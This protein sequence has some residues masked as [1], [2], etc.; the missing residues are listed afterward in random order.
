MCSQGAVRAH[1]LALCLGLHRCLCLYLHA[2]VPHH[3]TG[4]CT[5]LK[6]VA[7]L[8]PSSGLLVV[9]LTAGSLT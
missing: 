8:D 7:F 2:C 9:L 6:K 4:L 3:S 1:T 5:N